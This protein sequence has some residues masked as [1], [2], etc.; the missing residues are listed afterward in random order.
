MQF[1]GGAG[2]FPFFVLSFR[3]LVSWQTLFFSLWYFNYF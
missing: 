1:N 3:V 2:W